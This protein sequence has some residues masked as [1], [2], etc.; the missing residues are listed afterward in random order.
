MRTEREHRIERTRTGKRAW[1]PKPGGRRPRR[2]LL[3]RPPRVDERG[4]RAPQAAAPG[5]FDAW[6]AEHGRQLQGGFQT[7]PI[8]RLTEDGVDWGANPQP[9][10]EIGYGMHPYQGDDCF[11][12]AI[13]T[14]TQVPIEQVP[15]LAL[16]KRL[17]HG[18]DAEEISRTS[19][20]R[21]DSWAS[22]RGLGVAFWD[23]VPAPRHRWIGVCRNA[24]GIA[25]TFDEHGHPV[26]SDVGGRGFN[27][28]C[29]VMSHD[30]LIWDPSCSMKPPPGMTTSPSD[31][32]R[33]GYGISF[34]AID[35][36]K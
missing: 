9:G 31:T 22:K 36:R 32:T 4:W 25:Y 2:V 17:E 33:I 16:M 34:D 5:N 35:E 6:A 26:R 8:V 29:L 11:R 28:H 7:Y 1:R 15:D 18:E 3:Q 27:D 24:P 12:A 30:Q 23:E 21:I 14:A 19:W 10:D 13:A 20:E